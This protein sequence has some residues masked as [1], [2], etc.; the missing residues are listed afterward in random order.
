MDTVLLTEND[1][2]HAPAVAALPLV[3]PPATRRRA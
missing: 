2:E 1:L 3:F